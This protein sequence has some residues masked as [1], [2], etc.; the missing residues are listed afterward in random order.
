MDVSLNPEL[1][2]YL[3]S[4]VKAGRFA[5]VD[6]A[7]NQLLEAI[8]LAEELTPKNFQLRN[9]DIPHSGTYGG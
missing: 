8:K 6:D 7:V 5:S 2:A 1:Q 3:E 9:E 4:Q